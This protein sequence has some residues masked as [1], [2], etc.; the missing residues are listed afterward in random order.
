MRPDDED[1][2]PGDAAADGQPE[3]GLW[4]LPSEE[5][6]YRSD[7]RFPPPSRRFGS[8]HRHRPARERTVRDVLAIGFQ[9]K[10]KILST[11]LIIFSIGAIWI[12]SRPREFKSEMKILVRHARAGEVIGA[13]LEQA[14]RLM[15]GVGRAE[16]NTEAHILASRELALQ[17]LESSPVVRDSF[18]GTKRPG[19]ATRVKS[20]IGGPSPQIAS[21]NADLVDDFM[22]R[23]IIS[24]LGDSN[25]IRVSFLSEDPVVAMKSLEELSS[26]Y[27]AKHLAVHRTS[28]SAEVFARE[29]ER[30]KGELTA[31]QDNLASLTLRHG[32]ANVELEKDILVRNLLTLQGEFES[33]KGIIASLESRQEILQHEAERTPERRTTSVRTSPMLI[34]NLRQE[35]NR[36]DLQRIELE[37]KFLPDYGP[38]VQVKQQILFTQTAIDRA[39][40]APPVEETTD[41]DPTFDWVTAELARLRAELTGVR[42]KQV[43][44]DYT[45]TSVKT[46]SVE[47]NSLDQL[48]VD[49]VRDAK[50]AEQYFLAYKQRA[51]EARIDDE[52][53]RQRITN[54]TIAEAP[55]LPSKPTGPGRSVLALALLVLSAIP[56][57][58][59]GVLADILDPTFRRPDELEDALGL[60][61]LASI[62][63]V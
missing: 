48:R 41:R 35:L 20:W 44:L 5:Q 39:Q 52:L 47:L 7:D 53:D 28:G 62:P 55:S 13:G 10:R 9:Q 34:Q 6:L 60:P 3:E 16:I 37:A 30:H 15:V 31:L 14:R 46:R 1:R 58:A 40:S 36:L 42:S 22:A 18:A 23:L 50:V 27:L 19:L 63:K 12:A 29:A 33:N 61:V 56:A 45:I 51:E 59:V 2:V 54:V 8:A 11:F 57:L 43:E 25:V 32:V 4:R 26:V 24:P 21:S 38:V 17:V 49:L